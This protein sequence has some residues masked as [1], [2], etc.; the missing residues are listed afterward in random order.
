[1]ND[2]NKKVSGEEE[3]IDIITLE[4]EDGKE[5]DFEFIGECEVEGIIYY[6]VTPAGVQD[7][8]EGIIEYT[9][10]KLIKD[11]NGDEMYVSVDDE[12]EFDKVAGIFDDMFD[13]EE[14]YD[15]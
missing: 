9:L 4:D 15:V 13:S 7:E 8:N 5:I 14:D 3:E 10:L 1:M 6:A 11:E 2:E 12:D